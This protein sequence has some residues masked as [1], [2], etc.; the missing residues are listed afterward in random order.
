MPSFVECRDCKAVIY[1]ATA[2]G[3]GKRHP[4]NAEP[5]PK[6]LIKVVIRTFGEGEFKGRRLI[7]T[8]FRAVPVE[9]ENRYTSHFATCGK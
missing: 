4:L 3:T 1:W 9:G 8:D 6:G 2:L 7:I 5:D